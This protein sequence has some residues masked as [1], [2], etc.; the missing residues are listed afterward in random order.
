MRYIRGGD[1]H[2]LLAAAPGGLAPELVVALIADAAAAL[3][4]SHSHAVLHRDVKPANLLIEQHPRH[5]HQ[6]LLTD[7]GIARTLDSTVTL[8]A[9]SASFA[10]AAPERFTRAPSDHRSDIYSLGCTLFHLLTGRPPFPREDQAAV[11]GAHLSEPPPAPSMV[12]PDL[13]AGLNRVIATALAKD[14]EKRYPSCT[15]LAD[16]ARQAVTSASAA[17][18]TSPLSWSEPSVR[19]DPATGSAPASGAT[20]ANSGSGIPSAALFA[21]Q[22]A[23]TARGP[24]APVVPPPTRRI[25]RSA[26]LIGAAVTVALLAALAY[27]VIAVLP[28]GETAN[29][30]SVADTESTSTVSAATPMPTFSSSAACTGLSGQVVTDG[31]GDTSTPAGVIAAFEYAYYV[32]RDPDAVLELFIPGY[33]MPRAGLAAG[34]ASVPTTTT[35]C[36]AITLTVRDVAQV[37]LVELRPGNDRRSKDEVIYLR[38]NGGEI[39]I[40]EIDQV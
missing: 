20:A 23:G 30:G 36:V 1:A 33:D 24:A 21:Q 4:Y 9:V 14:P 8:S 27:A 5:G 39:L 38:E 11:V 34:I 7:F 2:T 13:P 22:M 40:A 25:G 12:R 35:H 10:Y 28:T 17:A 18:M 6:A 16:A 15:A 29:S 37:K 3:D 26:L 19:D 31:P 32:R